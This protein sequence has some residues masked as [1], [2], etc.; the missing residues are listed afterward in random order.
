MR[1]KVHLGTLT[2]RR[3]HISLL[4]RLAAR[5]GLCVAVEVSPSGTQGP[6]D[7]SVPNLEL[8]F[9]LEM[10]IHG[11]PRDG[12]ASKVSP[13]KLAPFQR[14][15]GAF[16]LV[17]D[18]SGDAGPQDCRIWRL[19]FSGL[20]GEN[21][22]L[23]LLVN[24]Q[25]PVAEIL[26][27]Q[28]TIAVG[29]L[30]T[31][32]NGILLATFEDILARTITLILAAFAGAANSKLPPIP[33]DIPSQKVAG[34]ISTRSLTIQ[35]L[36]ELTF[37]ISSII[38]HLCYNSPHWR[39]GWREIIG[40]DTIEL[41]RHPASGWRDLPDDGTRFYADPF[42]I[43]FQDRLTLFVEDFEHKTA[44][45][46]ISAVSFT[47]QGP[48]GRPEPVLELSY[49]LSYPFVFVEEGQAWM[50][51]E[52]TTA[53]S[54]DLFRATSFPGGWV[55]EATLVTSVVASDPTLLHHHG[56]WWMFATV[57]DGGG[58]FS[59]ALHLWSAPHFRGPWVPHPRNPVLIDIASARPAGRIVVRNGTLFRPVQDC[60]QGYGQALGIARI[61]KLDESCFEQEVDTIL[62]SGPAWRGSRVHTLNSAGGVEFIDGSRRSS[63]V[64]GQR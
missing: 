26:E 48:V 40:L 61:L 53:G 32:Y 10:L 54:I 43:Q 36:K 6:S 39:V 56:R 49:H 3:W 13:A 27:S 58:A 22:L 31:E 28:T 19:A 1:L 37:R 29:R 18:L 9:Q 16:D 7:L 41:G 45:G 2:I 21:A 57:R 11:I 30:G 33:P 47:T 38:Y 64:F 60:R 55:K 8:L 20:S 34:Q 15:A 5:P 12:L 14:S 24:G 35:A 25:S 52:S 50:I 4:K 23:G 51:P 44:K 46:V 59:D 42:P 62:T 17:L 63:W